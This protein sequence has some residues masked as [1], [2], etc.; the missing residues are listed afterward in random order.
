M[1]NIIVVSMVKK[2]CELK[3]KAK[4]SQKRIGVLINIK[5]FILYI[6]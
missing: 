4:N 5:D 6:Q 1:G 2:W 3:N